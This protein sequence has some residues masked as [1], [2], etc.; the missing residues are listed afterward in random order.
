MPRPFDRTN[1]LNKRFKCTEGQVLCFDVQRLPE[2]RGNQEGK[3]V[4]TASSRFGTM[5]SPQF[6]RRVS[7]TRSPDLNPS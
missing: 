7:H 3:T 4:V 2:M 5:F 1:H 6:F